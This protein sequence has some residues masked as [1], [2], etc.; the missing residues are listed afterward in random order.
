MIIT[1]WTTS[2]RAMIWAEA[3]IKEFKKSI[4]FLLRDNTTITIKK[5]DIIS[6]EEQ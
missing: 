5:D 3:V 2:G 1:Y 6:I 4:R